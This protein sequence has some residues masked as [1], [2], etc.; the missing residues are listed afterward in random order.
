LKRPLAAIVI[1]LFS[2]RVAVDDDFVLLVLVFEL[3]FHV[4]L[5]VYRRE[6]FLL[7]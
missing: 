5:L 4:W 2:N 7:S 3:R 1:G 6:S